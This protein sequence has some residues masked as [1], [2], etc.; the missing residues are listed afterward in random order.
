MKTTLIF[1]ACVLVVNGAK[2]E[3]NCDREAEEIFRQDCKHQCGVAEPLV[4]DCAMCIWKH[5]DY[6]TACKGE[7][8]TDQCWK[9][10]A[11]NGLKECQEGK[12]S[13]GEPCDMDENVLCPKICRLKDLELREFSLS[14]WANLVMNGRVHSVFA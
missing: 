9:I 2:L 8:K 5:Q 4:D 6:D 14:C 3:K 1:L 10:V 12:L 7:T 11:D 13:S